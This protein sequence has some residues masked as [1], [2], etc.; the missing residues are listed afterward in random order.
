MR[1]SIKSKHHSDEGVNFL[2]SV[3]DLT[4]ALL[5]VFIIAL[6]W[7]T[8]Q[9]QQAAHD[10][11][12][13]KQNA[14]AQEQ[15]TSEALEEAKRQAEQA[16][17]YKILLGHANSRIFGNKEDRSKLMEAVKKEIENSMHLKVDIDATKGILRVPEDAVTFQ[18]GSAELSEENLRR[19]EVMGRIFAEILPCYKAFTS[20][21]SRSDRCL[22]LNP[23][24]NML[25]A[26]F[27]EGHTDNQTF[28]GD[29]LENRNRLLSTSRSN[30]VYQTMVLGN[31]E[32]AGMTN[33]NGESLFSLSGYGA[34]RP[35]P[36][37]HHDTPTSDAANRRI[38]F[39]F[40]FTEPKL[41][42]EDQ[43][44]LNHRSPH[45]QTEL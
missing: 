25:D 13:A 33:S 42:K 2:A 4:S 27:I 10:A 23:D 31:P 1:R 28:N 32:L 34:D 24:G 41:T 38:E 26:V 8:M 44:L 29:T 11:E 14:L 20:E 37:H 15:K 18:T 5:F 30:T 22:A 19:V 36:G 39:R 9:A 3:S 12:K 21:D 40:I 35:L 43:E 45:K 17:E 7:A 16:E 6:A